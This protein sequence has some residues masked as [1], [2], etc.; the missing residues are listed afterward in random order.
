MKNQLF[1]NDTKEISVE[2]P[3]NNFKPKKQNQLTK[4]EILKKNFTK[5]IEIKKKPILL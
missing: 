4:T 5:Q 3:K 2:Q 1:Q